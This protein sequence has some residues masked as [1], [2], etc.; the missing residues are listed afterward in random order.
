MKKSNL[1]EI[2]RLFS[3][4][5]FKEFGDFVRSPFFNKN[6]VVLKLY[7]HLK[8]YY[9]ELDNDDLEKEKVYEELTGKSDY[10]DGYMRTVIF[11]LSKLAEDYL[12][13]T[14]INDFEKEILLMD[15]F[16]KRGSDK[17]FEKKMKQLSDFLSKE[18][19][20]DQYHFYCLYRLQTLKI[21]YNSRKRAF[22]NIKDFHEKE[23]IKVLDSLLSFYLLASIPEYRFFYNQANVVNIDLKFPFLDEIINFLEKSGY[24]KNVTLLN[25]YYHELLLARNDN[26]VNFY[27]LK[28]IVSKDIDTY[29]FGVKYN[30][31]G[32]LAN[33]AV[34]EYYRGNDK[35]LN[36]RFEIHDLIISKGLYKKFENGFFD[37]MLFKNIVI[38]G[39]QL[40]KVEWTENFIISYIDKLDPVN[41]NNAY[42][43]NM[44]RLEFYKGN[45]VKALELLNK[46]RNIKHVHYKTE[47][48]ILTL[49]IY[50]EEGKSHEAVSVIDNYRHFLSN[51]ALIPQIRKIRNNN[52]IKFVN[53][54]IKLKEEL[55]EKAIYDLQ[56]D[57]K[58][59]PNTYEKEWLLLKT[60]QLLKSI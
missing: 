58:N 28:K 19:K 20:I 2:L 25:L 24:H 18:T 14:A 43:L 48:K 35:F 29:T 7:E 11:N 42:N 56:Y 32:L 34:N 30:S 59:T 21:S 9:P 27:K 17:L 60:E 52:F 57:I 49:M 47:I 40:N 1:I 36:E 5:E 13:Y 41:R 4:K 3:Q 16:L 6:E 50:Y 31:T 55:L 15:A 44:G 53:E 51:D 54:L 26:E 39:L 8:R 33:K 38:V 45:Y 23:E 12:S 37:D 22:L 46:I 10:N